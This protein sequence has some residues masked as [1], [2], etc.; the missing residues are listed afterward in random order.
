MQSYSQVDFLQALAFQARPHD[1]RKDEAPPHR[2]GRACG[3]VSDAAALEWLEAFEVGFGTG[4]R[5][6]EC[7]KPRSRGYRLGLPSG[8]HFEVPDRS[9]N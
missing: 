1:N 8:I 2:R 7:T 9:G 3:L 5:Q 6:S 4:I